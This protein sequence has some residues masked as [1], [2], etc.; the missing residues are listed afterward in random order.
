MDIPENL[1]E[2]REWIKYQLRL[3]GKNLASVAREL[4]VS[5]HASI[6]ALR[7]PYP[8]MEQA[9]AKNL[10]VSPSTL[11]PER[12]DSHG[13]PNRRRGRPRS[14][15]KWKNISNPMDEDDASMAP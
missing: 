6:L 3:R 10:G 7:K 15:G 8:R 5:R 14:N 2:R 11:W 9:I 4:G 12:Y 13:V 1:H